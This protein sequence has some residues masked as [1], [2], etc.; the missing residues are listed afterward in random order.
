MS[1]LAAELLAVGRKA[2]AEA[3]NTIAAQITNIRYGK[4]GEILIDYKGMTLPIIE[5]VDVL[6]VGYNDKAAARWIASKY[7]NLFTPKW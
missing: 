7:L 6:L 1:Y 4:P 5:P 2:A 3:V